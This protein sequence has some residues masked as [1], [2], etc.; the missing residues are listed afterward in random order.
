MS[1]IAKPKVHHPSL[2]KNALG[3]TRRDYEGANSTLCAGCGYD[4]I[5]AALIDESEFDRAGEVLRQLPA[6]PSVCYVRAVLGSRTRRWPDVL[7]AIE[8]EKVAL[9]C[10]VASDY[11]KKVPA[12]KLIQ[13]IAPLVGGKGGGR[14]ELAQGGGND[15]GGVGLALTEAEAFVRRAA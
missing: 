15:P 3:L 14:P 13:A 10:S 2:P 9:L 7:V 8:G 1:Y 12:G 5:T 6:I 4:S 11:A